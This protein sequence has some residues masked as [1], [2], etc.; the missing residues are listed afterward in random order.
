MTLGGSNVAWLIVRPG[1]TVLQ[2]CS[3]RCRNGVQGSSELDSRVQSPS[4][5]NP[6]PTLPVLKL[7]SG[8][9]DSPRLTRAFYWCSKVD[10]II[11][12]IA[13]L[14]RPP[15]KNCASLAHI[16]KSHAEISLGRVKKTTESF[17]AFIL[18]NSSHFGFRKSLLHGGHQSHPFSYFFRYSRLLT[19]KCFSGIANMEIP[20]ERPEYDV[21]SYTQSRSNDSHR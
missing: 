6:E 18:P 16:L 19:S 3:S 21:K 4:H 14:H 12:V 11:H 10:T 9:D 7:I 1:G 5:T 15:T 8:A 17:L 13:T 2:G 20:F